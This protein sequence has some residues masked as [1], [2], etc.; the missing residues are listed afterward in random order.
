MNANTIVIL[1]QQDKL[2]KCII[3]HPVTLHKLKIGFFIT[4]T[5][6]VHSGVLN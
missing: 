3:N 2:I 4:T 6:T 5:A 1:L